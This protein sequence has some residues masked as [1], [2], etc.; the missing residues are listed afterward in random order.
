MTLKHVHLIPILFP[1]PSSIHGSFAY[2]CFDTLRPCHYK[3]KYTIRRME[4]VHLL[5]LKF[6]FVTII[7]IHTIHFTSFMVR[8]DV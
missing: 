3:Y 1:P 6:V 2:E 7:Y 8:K 5:D 4:L